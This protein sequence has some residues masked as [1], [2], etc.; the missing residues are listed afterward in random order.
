MR[1][2]DKVN[3]TAIAMQRHG[4]GF[5]EALGVALA[6]ADPDNKMRIRAAFPEYW[7]QYRTIAKMEGWYVHE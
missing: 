2:F 1:E 7:K 6:L 3:A 5:V 4:G